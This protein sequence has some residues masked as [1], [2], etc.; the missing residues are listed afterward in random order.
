M[1]K[2]TFPYIATLAVLTGLVTLTAVPASADTVQTANLSMSVTSTLSLTV[3]V[4]ELVGG[5]PTGPDLGTTMNFGELVKDGANAQ[6][7]TRSFGVFLSSATS[8]RAYTITA[9]MASPTSGANTLP[10]ATLLKIISATKNGADITGDAFNAAAQ[11]AVMSNSVVY[12]S[13]PAGDS[14]LVNLTYGISGANPDGSAPFP[15][16]VGISP[17]FPGGEYSSTVSYSLVL[18]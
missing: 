13:S 7:G 16:W 17:D 5:V 2:L 4:K 11:S 8:G 14:A 6:W 18:L 10:N 15:G 3:A 9:T 1:K 12:T